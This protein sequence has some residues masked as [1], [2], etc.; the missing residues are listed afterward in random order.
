M[1]RKD[2]IVNAL[3]FGPRKDGISEHDCP[4]EAGN[5]G[6]DSCNVCNKAVHNKVEE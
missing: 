6:E 5:H 1:N 4:Y 3:I 2:Q